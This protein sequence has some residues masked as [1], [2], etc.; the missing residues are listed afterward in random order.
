M[1]KRN[2][3]IVAPLDWG[4]G[5]A[6]RCIP[7]IRTLI[8]CGQEVWIASSGSALEVMKEEFPSLPALELPGY[9]VRYPE[10]G[11]LAFAMLKQAPGILRSIQSE[12]RRLKDIVREHK[13]DAIISDNRF[14]CWHAGIPSVFITHQ[15]HLQAPPQFRWAAGIINRMNKNYM[16][17]FHECWIPDE[18]THPGLA[19]KLSHPSLNKERTYYLGPLSRF[20]LSN[21]EHP[22]A[23][24]L[25][26]LLS[27]PEPQRTILEENLFRQL[28]TFG[29][30]VLV[31]RGLPGA[32]PFVVPEKNVEVVSSLSSEDLQQA[33]LSSEFL[34]SRAGYSS[35]MD[36]LAL[37][38]NAIL[39]P[40]PGQT[41]QEYLARQFREQK[42]F[43]SMEQ[44]DFNLAEAMLASKGYSVK[45]RKTNPADLTTH[46]EKWLD[47]ISSS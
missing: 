17:R 37:E 47:R 7:I 6:T 16:A 15:L 2:R 28:K 18:Q 33:I 36:Y 13:P 31:V 29:R 42:V 39:V 38:K 45:N 24:K 35:I 4:L 22:T 26:I 12:H 44:N 20:K 11:S 30:R 41:E 46:I 1:A 9:S 23:Y 10:K 40:T 8:A 21:R 34:V 27:G 32:P 43:Y 19:G 3:I 14:G 5:H 25:C